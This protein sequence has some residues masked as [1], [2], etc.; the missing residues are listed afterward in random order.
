[1]VL[2][3]C[4]RGMNLAQPCFCIFWSSWW[5]M[6]KRRLQGD[7]SAAFPYLKGADKKDGD[8][9]FI[10]VCCNRTRGDGFKLKEGTFRPDMRK[11]LFTMKVMR[12]CP[13]L[14]REW[15]NHPW[16]H[17]RPGWTGL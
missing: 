14:A 10:R 17:P 4:G 5:L 15:I 1:M 11:K 13:R 2:L 12:A 16:R 3:H 9:L 7:L 6:E 8:R